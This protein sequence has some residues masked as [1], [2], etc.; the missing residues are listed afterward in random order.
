MN[1]KT[2]GIAIAILIAFC[3]G[4]YF[5][6]E[7]QKQKFD[8]SLPK[9]PAVEQQQ[10][11]ATDD[12]TEDTAAGHWKPDGDGK[13]A[14]PHEDQA[15]IPDENTSNGDEWLT[16][17]DPSTGVTITTDVDISELLTASEIQT[18][19]E[20]IRRGDVHRHPEKLSQREIEYLSHVGIDL[21]MVP[22]DIRRQRLQE[23]EREF[24][25]Q[26][27]L[28]PPPEGYG[29]NFHDMDKGILYLDENGMPILS[30]DRTGRDV[31]WA[32]VSAHFEGDPYV[33]K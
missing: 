2:L 23:I 33:Q 9:P 30:D 7:W 22:P 11:T 8:A 19:N 25:G 14:G 3:A 10:D 16:I 15:V 28:K 20:K 4:I 32:E 24:Y 17:G 13:P 1:R 26:Y 27:G 5:W 6:A 12:V 29:Y 31:P 21:A 18:L